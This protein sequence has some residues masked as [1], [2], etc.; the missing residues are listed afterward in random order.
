MNRNRATS[1]EARGAVARVTPKVSERRPQALPLLLVPGAGRAPP[2]Q[3]SGVYGGVC[4]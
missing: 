2:P 4:S 3:I 1:W